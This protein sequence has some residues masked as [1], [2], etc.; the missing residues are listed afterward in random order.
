MR[1]TF[2]FLIVLI[3]TTGAA[4]AGEDAIKLPDGHGKEAVQNNCFGCHSL[5]YPMMNSPF[6]DQKGWEAEVTKM[7]KAYGAPVNEADIPQIVTYLTQNYG[8]K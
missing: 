6:L 5:D 8:K 4:R 7:M 3:A 2:G 1:K